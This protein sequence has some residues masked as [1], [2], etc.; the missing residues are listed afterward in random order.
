MSP[1]EVYG[2]YLAVK[3]HFSDWKYDFHKYRGKL[4]NVNQSTFDTR[5]D[6]WVF[7]KLAREQ[8]PVGLIVANVL[9]GTARWPGS[10]TKD[11]YLAM[12]GRQEGLG[13]LLRQELPR[14]GSKLSDAMLVPEG[15]H[16]L[17]FREYLA[18]RVSPETLAVLVSLTYSAGYYMKYESDTVI[19]DVLKIAVKYH[20]FVEYDRD[21]ILKLVVDS[22]S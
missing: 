22:F 7:E 5:R 13:Y 8:D 17:L 21:K 15:K 9:A 14:L 18:G 6:K 11:C 3:K 2:A 10:M 19:Q 20:S 16:P 12:R 1:G 4:K